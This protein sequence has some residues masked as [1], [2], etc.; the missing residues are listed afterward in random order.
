MSIVN[1]DTKNL[2]ELVS[3]VVLLFP[4]SGYDDLKDTYKET[5]LS[6]KWQKPCT[7]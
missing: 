3:L 7:F 1:A 2:N 4:D 6:K 5:L